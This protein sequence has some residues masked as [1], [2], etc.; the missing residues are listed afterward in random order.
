[1]DSSKTILEETTQVITED[2]TSHLGKWFLKE[3]KNTF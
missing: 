2:V 3:D 1:M